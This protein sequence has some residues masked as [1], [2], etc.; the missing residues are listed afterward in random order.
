MTSVLQSVEK[1]ML[2]SA[3]S[4]SGPLAGLM[5]TTGNAGAWSVA[6]SVAWRSCLAVR[7][8]RAAALTLIARI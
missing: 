1:A 3:L 4:I 8:P 5:G 6:C 7:V 2:S